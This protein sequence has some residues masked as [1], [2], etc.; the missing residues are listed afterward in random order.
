MDAVWDWHGWEWDGW[1]GVVAVGAFVLAFM[2]WRLARATKR[3]AR[4]TAGV[5]RQ[6]RDL[7]EA[8]KAALRAHSLPLLV[9]AQDVVTNGAKDTVVHVRSVGTGAAMIARGSPPR[10]HLDDADDWV[11]GVT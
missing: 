9:D 8:D 3:L 6:T 11:Q 4:E 1:A 5:A 10:I 2:I 7:A